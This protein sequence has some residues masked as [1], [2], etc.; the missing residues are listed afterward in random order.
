ML[1]L[2]LEDGSF[3]STRLPSDAEY[4]VDEP[5]EEEPTGAIA[6]KKHSRS[7]VDDDG[8]AAAPPVHRRRFKL[9]TA[10]VLSI[11]A[12]VMVGSILL[13]RHIFKEK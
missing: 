4:M 7:V 2:F 12:V 5:N 6:K 1:R 9:S 13:F 11:F 3:E 10:V 8:A